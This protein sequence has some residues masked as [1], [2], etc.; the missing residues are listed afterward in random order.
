MQERERIW[1]RGNLTLAFQFSLLN[2]FLFAAAAQKV[3]TFL[4]GSSSS[5]SARAGAGVSEANWP[6]AFPTN[7]RSAHVVLG[8]DAGERR[9]MNASLLSRRMSM[10]MWMWFSG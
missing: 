8:N 6:M 9:N 10:W 3:S 5:S 4:Q 7:I 1:P 2:V